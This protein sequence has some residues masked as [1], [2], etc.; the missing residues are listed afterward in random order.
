MNATS[1]VGSTSLGA[2]RITACA[3]AQVA[4]RQ[5]HHGPCSRTYRFAGASW[6]A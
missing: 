6:S 3:P 1:A 5:R 2:A 4:L